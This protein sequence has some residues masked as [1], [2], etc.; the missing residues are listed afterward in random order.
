M[1]APAVTVAACYA[2]F[3]AV[4]TVPVAEGQSKPSFSESKR[5]IG[6]WRLVSFESN[7]QENPRARGARPVGLILYDATGYMSAQMMP[8]RVRRKFTGPPSPVF[9]G[10]RPTAEEALDAI[11]GYTAYFGTYSV[12]EQARTITHHRL[13]NLDPG[14]LGDFVRRYEFAN[15]DRL[16][17][18]P[19]DS[20]NLRAAR[21]TV[22]RIK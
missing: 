6:A 15:E 7:D 4:T 5:L 17:L 12:D 3:I 18:T 21:V 8:D 20:P 9:A 22:E 2:V 13:G 1:K 10:P 19:L 14:A 16:I 11:F